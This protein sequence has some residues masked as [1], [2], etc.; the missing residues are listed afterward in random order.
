MERRSPDNRVRARSGA[1]ETHRGY[2]PAALE[3][4]ARVLAR[5]RTDGPSSVGEP[6]RLPLSPGELD[7]LEDAANGLTI[8][9]LS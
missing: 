6:R 2:D 8:S 7:V 5:H 1:A 9:E 3:R 4:L